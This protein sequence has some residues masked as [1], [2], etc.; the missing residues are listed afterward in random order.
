MASRAMNCE[1]LR[2]IEIIKIAKSVQ[3]ILR[4]LSQRLIV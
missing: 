1:D 2:N 4:R 3:N